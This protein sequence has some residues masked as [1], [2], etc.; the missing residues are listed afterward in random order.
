MLPNL[1]L[2]VGPGYTLECHKRISKQAHPISAEEYLGF[3][4]SATFSSRVALDCKSI[5]DNSGAE[6]LARRPESST[7]NLLLTTRLLMRRL[8]STKRLP[9]RGVRAHRKSRWFHYAIKIL[10]VA[11]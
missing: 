4:S 3:Q 2:W 8:L 9:Y 10:T 1:S 5:A 11:L 6:R 7:Q